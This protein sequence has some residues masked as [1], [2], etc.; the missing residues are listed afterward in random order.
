MKIYKHDFYNQNH[1]LHLGKTGKL[2]IFD[3]CDMCGLVLLKEHVDLF[4]N[5]DAYDY[6]AQHDII[7]NLFPCLTED[8]L[9]IKGLLEWLC[10]FPAT[11]I[12]FIKTY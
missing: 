2:M 7:N 3:K 9:T 8:E 11:N 6:K 4:I 12:F 1:R 10:I 5:I